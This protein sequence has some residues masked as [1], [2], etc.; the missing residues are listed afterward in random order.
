MNAGGNHISD[1]LA[2]KVA[3]QEQVINVSSVVCFPCSGNEDDASKVVEAAAFVVAVPML[4]S[5][6]S[7]VD[8]DE[9][10]LWS[11]TFAEGSVRIPLD[12][13]DLLKDPQDFENAWLQLTWD[14][15]FPYLNEKK[16]CKKLEDGKQRLWIQVEIFHIEIKC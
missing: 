1:Q 13:Q 14:H 9:C 5:G 11:T 16:E 3:Q 6:V 10:T 8:T 12:L 7:V 2:E 4:T 15:F